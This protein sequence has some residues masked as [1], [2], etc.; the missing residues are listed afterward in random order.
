MSTKW[1]ILAPG[2]IA[3]KFATGLQAVPGAKLHAVGSRSLHRA[4]AFAKEYGADR[5]F[6]SYREL[7]EDPDT[8]IIYIATPHPAHYESAVLCLENGKAVLCEKPFTMNLG[9]LRHLVELARTRDVF[10]MEAFWTRF[11]PGIVKILEVAESGIL[12][13]VRFI[14]ADFGFRGEY[15]PSNRLFNPALGGGALLDIGVYVVFLSLL[16]LG[17]PEDIA[18]SSRFAET[19]VDA[20]TAMIFSYP[21]DRM[22]SLYCTFTADTPTRADITFDRGRISIEGQWFA[23]SNPVIYREDGSREVFE[24]EE[25]SNGYQYEA[26]E[27]MRCLDKG[28]TESPFLNLDFSLDLMETLDRIREICGI[29]Y[30]QDG[31]II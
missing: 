19:G 2:K 25:K 27:C 14:S 20:S 18:A 4:E 13:R 12:G 5:A 7:A 21:G 30:A 22:A 16:L 1:G 9:Q 8:D 28:L 10:L 26:I 29:R 6:G 31:P 11:I 23:P 24:Y 3:H 17:K 15:D